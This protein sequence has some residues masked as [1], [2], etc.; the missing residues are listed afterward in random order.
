MTVVSMTLIEIL[1]AVVVIGFLASALTAAILRGRGALG[2][3]GTGAGA[4]RAAAKQFVWVL[5]PPTF[6]VDTEASFTFRL[7]VIDPGSGVGRAMPG[8]DVLVGAVTPATVRIIRINGS[9][10]GSSTVFP[11]YVGIPGTA[12]EAETD[13]GG[14]VTLVLKGSE[15]ADA[16]LYVVYANGP[17]DKA[18]QAK[19]FA[20]T[21]P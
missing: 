16:R 4:P 2:V 20:V 19:D 10:P 5:A 3:G 17:N 14:Q 1:I 13:N 11:D 15:A 21:P 7:E 9:A 18:A 8:K 12:F 6:P